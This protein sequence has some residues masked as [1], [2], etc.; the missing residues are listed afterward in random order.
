MNPPV[1]PEVQDLE[2]SRSVFVFFPQFA[3]RN[4]HRL[5]QND[6]LAARGGWSKKWDAPVASQ[7][8]LNPHSSRKVGL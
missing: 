4:D 5:A 3:E 2:R 1:G 8:N 6:I 7:T